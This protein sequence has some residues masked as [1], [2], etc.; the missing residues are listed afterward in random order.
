MSS[1]PINWTTVPHTELV[2]DS[3][4]NAKVA[5]RLELERVQTSIA[6][7]RTEDLWKIGTLMRSPFI[8]SAKG[9]EKEVE[10]GAEAEEKGDEADNEDEDAQ[11]EEE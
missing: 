9:K 10:T 2:S 3:E 7:Q 4:D 5:E 1:R 8:Y 6:Q 11:G